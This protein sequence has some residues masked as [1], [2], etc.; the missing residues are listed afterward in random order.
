[1]VEKIL[2]EV[3]IED[4]GHDGRGV[5]KVDGFTVFI[6]GALP[7]ELIRARMYKKKKRYGEAILE[8][9]IDSSPQ[10]QDPPCPVYPECGGCQ[11]QH[12]IYSYQMEFKKERVFQVLQRIGE[13]EKIPPPGLFPSPREWK[14]RNKGTYHLQE[15]RAG[16]YSRQSREVI[17][18]RECLLQPDGANRLKRMVEDMWREGVLRGG[19]NFTIRTSFSKNSFLL[20]F[21]SRMRSQEDWRDIGE[22]LQKNLPGLTGI[23]WGD[24]RDRRGKTVWGR[25]YIQEEMGGLS[26]FLRP[27]SFFQINPEQREV[28]LQRAEEH[29]RLSG[30]EVV[31]DLY[32]GAGV[33]SLPLSAQAAEILGVELDPEAIKEGRRQARE[34]GKRN[35]R[36]YEGAVEDILSQ[37]PEGLDRILLDPPREGCKPEALA[38]MGEK[39]AERIVYISCNPATL[40]RDIKYLQPLGYRLVDVDIVDMFPQ[41]YHIEC[42]AVLSR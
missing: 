22:K 25:G 24:M 11:L 8:E 41:T 9:I 38:A 12:M 23:Y 17:G 13:T 18:H 32:C 26:Y 6:P 29:L 33:F 7:G 36:F 3:R 14:Y 39:G 28:L 30:Q 34:M 20:L 19:K 21:D 31:L 16:F 5:G 4:L 40:A 27:H 2:P 15:N 37:L 42:I 1:M 10:R 35:L